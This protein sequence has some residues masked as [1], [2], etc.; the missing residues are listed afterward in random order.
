MDTDNET[1]I[2]TTGAIT[3]IVQLQAIPVFRSCVVLVLSLML[4]QPVCSFCQ[5]CIMEMITMHDVAIAACHLYVIF[6]VSVQQ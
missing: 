1:S 5:C 6:H 2:S 4:L 3:V